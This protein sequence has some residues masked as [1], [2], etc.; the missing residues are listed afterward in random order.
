[1]YISIGYFGFES[2]VGVVVH[3]AEYGDPFYDNLG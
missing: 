1:M 2:L 3:S